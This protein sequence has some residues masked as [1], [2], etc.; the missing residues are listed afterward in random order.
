MYIQI[1][2]VKRFIFI[3][4]LN[5]TTTKIQVYVMVKRTFEIN[6]VA[7]LKK[8]KGN[9]WFKNFK[10][11]FKICYLWNCHMQWQYNKTADFYN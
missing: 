11:K 4:I 9:S 3:I 6:I 10:L 1:F 5:G 7:P 2:E 8:I